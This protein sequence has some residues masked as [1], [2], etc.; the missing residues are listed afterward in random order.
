MKRLMKNSIAVMLAFALAF[1]VGII[2]AKAAEKNVGLV[3][4]ITI[5][6]GWGSTNITHWFGPDSYSTDFSSYKVSADVYFP[7]TMIDGANDPNVCIATEIS[8]WVEDTDQ[9]A[10]LPMA[11]ENEIIV[12]FN[13]EAKEFW[14]NGYDEKAQKDVELPFVKSVTAVGDMVKVEIVDAPVLSTLYTTDWDEAT[15]FPKPWTAAIPEKNVHVNARVRLAGGNAFKGKF[16]VSNVSLKIGEKVLDVDYN[17]KE[18]IG[19]AFGDVE[20]DI[21]PQKAA[22]FNTSAVAVA[23]SSVSVKAKKSASVKV[24]TMFDGDKVT[25]SSSSKKVA[26]ATYKKGKV[27]IKGVKKGKATITV[28]ANGKS[29]KIKVTVK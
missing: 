20:G 29:K 14:Y 1:G 7:R 15:D 17:A 25:V 24:T 11:R 26:T 5:Q 10:Q 4:P 13:K 21:G 8:L 6:S 9:S 19:D 16:A 27:T 23:K 2:P 3:A 28:K 18:D 22:S 12:G